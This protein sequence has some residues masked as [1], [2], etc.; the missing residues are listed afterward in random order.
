M[1]EQINAVQRMQ[2]YIES[3]LFENIS[4]SA[5]SKIS[6][7][8]PWYSYRLFVNQTGLTPSV[9]IRIETA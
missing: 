9:K 1:L 2:D 8:S 3:H 7:Y 5:L 4:L 6:L